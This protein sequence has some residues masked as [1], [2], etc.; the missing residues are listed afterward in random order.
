MNNQ[1]ILSALESQLATK[2]ADLEL[3]ETSIANPAFKETTEEVLQS[4]RETVSPL[5]PSIILDKSRIEIMKS[6]KPNSW[7]AITISLTNDWGSEK[8]VRTVKINWYGSSATLEDQNTLN[9]LQVFGGV[10]SKIAWIEYEFINNWRPKLIEIGK[11]GNDLQEEIREINR[12]INSVKNQMRNDGVDSYKKEGFTCV[13]TPTL[14]ISRNYEAEG[15]L[16]ELGSTIPNIEL[17]IGRGKW[18]YIHAKSFKVL[19]TNK[20]KTTLEVTRGDNKVVEHTV[21]ARS[22]DKFISEVYT[23]QNE[24]AKLHND[25]ITERFNTQYAKQSA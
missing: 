14:N 3:H 13:L 22:F 25:K 12:S 19:K 5:I 9:D 20:Y 4:L 24:N 21:T 7:S 1:I 17:S 2:Q 15:I 6:G 8:S 11:L 23:W 16:Y 10:A 18:D